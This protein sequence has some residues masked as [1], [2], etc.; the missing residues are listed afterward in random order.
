MA[1]LNKKAFTPTTND[2]SYYPLLYVALKETSG[3]II[4]MGCGYGSTPLLNAYKNSRKLYSYENNPIWAAKMRDEGLDVIPLNNWDDVKNAH[5]FADVVFIDHAPGERR[6][7][8]IINFKGKAKVIVCHDTE[9]A[10]DH[11]YQMRQHF[12]KFKYAAEVKTSGAWATILSDEIDV[13]KY[14]GEKFGNYTITKL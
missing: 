12:G 14:D 5:E 13:T 6:K 9:P 1:K 10:A 4:E 7:E 8:D 3:D 11:G 2:L